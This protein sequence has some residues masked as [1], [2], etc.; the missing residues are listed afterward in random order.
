MMRLS[1]RTAA[2]SDVPRYLAR[3]EHVFRVT[4]QRAAEPRSG[5][6]VCRACSTA[7]KLKSSTNLMEVKGSEAQG[8]S[9]ETVLGSAEQ[10]REPMNK[11]V[12]RGC[13]GADERAMH[14]EVHIHQAFE[15][16]NHAVVRRKRSNLPRE[17]WEAVGRLGEPR[18]DLKSDPAVSRGRSRCACTEGPN[19]TYRQQRR[20]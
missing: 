17:S 9:R 13:L 5:G 1:V 4:I 7:R 15:E 14:C 10:R 18:G 11:N 6:I 12:M 19:G 16:V 3:L 2:S 20:G 8:V